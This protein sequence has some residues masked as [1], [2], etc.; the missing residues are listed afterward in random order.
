MKKLT[1]A[2]RAVT[3]KLNH[4]V[5]IP[6]GAVYRKDGDFEFPLEIGEPLPSV[7][8]EMLV[9]KVDADGKGIKETY[10]KTGYTKV[11]ALKGKQ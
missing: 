5:K 4:I 7:V 6:P 11:K 2:N 1:E 3:A 9:E 10:R 8:K